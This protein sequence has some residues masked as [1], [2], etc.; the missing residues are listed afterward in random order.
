MRDLYAV[1][2]VERQAS[3]E[4][5]K[6]AY[7]KLSKKY[8]PD[9][10]PGS[11]EAE[12]KFMELSKAY[13]VLQDPEKRKAY[14]RTYGQHLNEEEERHQGK[15]Q[16]SGAGGETGAAFTPFAPSQKNREN[17]LDMTE[18][19]ERYMRIKKR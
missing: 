15:Q 9:A 3:E 10:N 19:F 6:K 16:R 13:A 1:L 5:I 8:H 12:R 14:D 2:G 7:R 17:P 4:T 11:R 18:L